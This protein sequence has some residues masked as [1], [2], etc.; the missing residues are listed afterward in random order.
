VFAGLYED[1]DIVEPLSRE[2]GRPQGD[3]KKRSPYSIDT[4]QGD[5]ETFSS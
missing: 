1:L 2:T 4:G 3:S 5:R